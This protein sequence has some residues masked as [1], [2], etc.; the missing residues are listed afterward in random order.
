MPLQLESTLA[1]L[2]IGLCQHSY[3]QITDNILQN[4]FIKTVSK[5]T[6]ITA[7]NDTDFYHCQIGYIFARSV[8]LPMCLWAEYLKKLRIGFDRAAQIND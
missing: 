4:T 5:L 3:T 1:S 8:S 6:D 2:S 7:L